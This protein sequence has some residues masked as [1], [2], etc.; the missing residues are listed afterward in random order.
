V[1]G[2]IVGRYRLVELLGTGGMSVVYLAEHTVLGK[3]VAI[4]LLHDEYS[5]NPR[6]VTRFM[7]EARAAARVRHPSIVD[8]HDC[9]TLDDG[10]AFLVMET[11]EGESLRTRLESEGRLPEPILLELLRQTAR[12]LSAAHAAGVIHRDLKPGNLFLSEDP[13]MPWGILVKVL[14]FGVCRLCEDDRIR[15]TLSGAVVGTP[16]YMA[17]EQCKNARNVDARSDIYSLGCIAFEMATGQPPFTERGMGAMM[18]AHTSSQ[19]PLHLLEET[20]SPTLAALIAR[21]LA[22]LPDARPASMHAVELALAAAA[23][24]RTEARAAIAAHVTVPMETVV[25]DTIVDAT[26]PG[27]DDPRRQ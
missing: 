25:N 24:E 21:M 18:L 27:N 12:A 17:P 13:T 6:V 15:L 9:G 26:V 19:P 11:L 7:D 4:K 22:K 5:R 2:T 14:D 3:Q 1:V 10:R 20:A 8:I 23:A 16:T